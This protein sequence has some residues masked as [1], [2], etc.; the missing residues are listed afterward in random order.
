LKPFIAK[1]NTGQRSQRPEDNPG[2]LL[3]DIVLNA[4]ILASNAGRS[5]TL[6]KLRSCRSEKSCQGLYFMANEQ[7]ISCKPLWTEAQKHRFQGAMHFGFAHLVPKTFVT[8]MPEGRASDLAVIEE[9]ARGEDGRS[10]YDVDLVV[11]HVPRG[12]DDDYEAADQDE[13][14][15]PFWKQP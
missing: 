4:A 9:S 6:C 3:G 14:T 8:I 7:Q 5:W 1:D 12:S 11:L 2:N 15:Q 13:T 10:A